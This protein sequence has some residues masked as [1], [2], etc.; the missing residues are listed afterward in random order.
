MAG[1]LAYMEGLKPRNKTGFVF[2]SYGWA[3]QGLKKITDIVGGLSWNMPSG[4]FFVH[5]R[6]DN[7]ALASL[8]K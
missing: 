2:G 7:D 1:F 3:D 8:K 6:P 4:P 5:Y